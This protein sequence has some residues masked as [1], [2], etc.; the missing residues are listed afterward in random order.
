MS[1]LVDS[2]RIAIISRRA[3][4]AAVGPTRPAK[5]PQDKEPRVPGKSGRD[6]QRALARAKLERQMARRAAAAR[7]RRQMQAGIGAIIAVVI[8]IAGGWFLISKFGGGN[9]TNANAAATPHLPA[10]PPPRRPGPVCTRRTPPTRHPRAPAA[11]A[12]RPP[13]TCHTPAPRR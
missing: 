2:P 8:V 3:P 10:C 6:R 9:K 5:T 1:Q 7:K 11:S 12:Y 13:R 4:T